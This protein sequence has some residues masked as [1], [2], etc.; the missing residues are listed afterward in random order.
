MNPYQR[1]IDVMGRTLEPFDDDHN[2]PA[3]GFGDATTKDNAVFPFFPDRPCHGFQ[4]VLSRYTEITPHVALSGPTN[5]GPLIREA[6]RLVRQTREYHIL[7]I[8]ADGQV[9]DEKDT[10]NAIVE[11]SNYPLSIVLIG[12]GDGPWEK[13]E[14]FDD[15]LPQ[16]RFDNFQFCNFHEVL[17]KYDGDDVAFAVMALQEI[18]EQYEAIR[19]H[20]LL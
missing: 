3:Y 16:R 9:T 20:K 19:K 5:F 12:V 2:I 15:G 8:V 18:P 10:V 1:V 14:E 17:T 11:A 6:I 13:M 4:E 7:L